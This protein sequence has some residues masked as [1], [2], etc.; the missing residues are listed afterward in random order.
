MH[1]ISDGVPITG[2]VDVLIVNFRTPDLTIQAVR[3]VLPEPELAEVVVVDNASGDGSA[4]RLDEYFANEPR[5]RIVRSQ[6]NVGFGAGNNIAARS[7]R[8]KYLFLLNSDAT[9]KPGCLGRLVSVLESASDVGLVAPAVFVADGERLQDATYG[10]FPTP[11]AI[12]LRKNIAPRDTLNPDWISGVAF[13][14]RREEYL[15]LGGFDEAFFMYHEDVDLCRRY[16]DCGF[17]V[18]RELSASVVHLLGQSSTSTRSKLAVYD[19][20]QDRYLVVSGASPIGRATVKI[21][22]GIYRRMRA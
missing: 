11:S 15:R 1:G 13:M 20:S 2:E 18:R 6:T 17:G 14:A 22:R 21:A 16:R 3:S 7:A 19:A 4:D 9:V 10:V 5:V 8:A 12:F